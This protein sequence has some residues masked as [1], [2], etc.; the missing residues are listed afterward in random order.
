MQAKQNAHWFLKTLIAHYPNATIELAWNKK[1]PWQ[2][3]VLVMLSAQ[4][5]DKN[6]NAISKDLFLA[7]PDMEAMANAK[8]DD[9][10]PYIRTLGFFRNKSKNLIACAQELMHKH[11]G[12]VPK[13]RA[14][15]EALPG[16]GPKTAAVVISNA[17]A[18]PA[19]AVDTHV[20][21]VSRRL[22]LTK[23]TDPSK[24]EADLQKLWPKNQWTIAHHTLIWHGRRICTAKKPKCPTCPV[25]SRCPKIGVQ[26]QDQTS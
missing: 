1:D 2:L 21:R 18:T 15:L 7:Y 5:T 26:A 16:V 6:V 13:E 14:Q 22:G 12:Q 25:C 4:T 8:Q 9:I 19:I 3:L 23:H 17:F 24:I 11:H 20:S 10:E